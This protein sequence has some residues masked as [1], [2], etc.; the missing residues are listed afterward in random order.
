MI[1]AGEGWSPQSPGAAAILDVGPG[2]AHRADG[3]AT[4]ACPRPGCLALEELCCL[5][6][7]L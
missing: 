6:A 5:S 4:N 3:W 7:H 1:L 2:V